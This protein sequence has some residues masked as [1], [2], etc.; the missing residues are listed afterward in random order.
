MCGVYMTV[1]IHVC[2]SCIYTS[3]EVE[4]GEGGWSGECV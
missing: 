1:Y 3:S 2:S 4:R